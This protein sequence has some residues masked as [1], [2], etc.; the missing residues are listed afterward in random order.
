M[1]DHGWG[2]A[3]ADGTA[4]GAALTIATLVTEGFLREASSIATYVIDADGTV[5]QTAL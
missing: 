5:H 4:G 3:T 2:Y 1:A